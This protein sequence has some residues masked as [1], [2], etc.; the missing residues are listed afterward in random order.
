MASTASA[1]IK[2][3]AVAG[4]MGM[5]PPLAR[6]TARF[7]TSPAISSPMPARLRFVQA[8]TNSNTSEISRLAAA[9]ISGIQVRVTGR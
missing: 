5:K 2:R 4:L 1:G 6:M 9:R 7:S 3:A 8:K